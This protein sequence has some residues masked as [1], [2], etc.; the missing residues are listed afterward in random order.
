MV[1]LQTL[2]SALR[3]LHTP[4]LLVRD[5]GFLLYGGPLVAF[6]VLLSLAGKL[7]QLAPWDLVRVYRAWGPSLGLSLG[8]AV[9]GAL[10]AYGI[11]HQG[12]SWGLATP[13]ERA[14]AL[15][16]GLFGAMWVSNLFLEIWSL[17]PLRK[18]DNVATGV[19][20]AAAY[21]VALRALQRH[22]WVHSALVLG[23]VIS[24]RLG[25]L[26]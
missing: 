21:D 7:P 23:V 25:G 20:D 11:E 26:L 8:A 14:A 15:T 3:D 10:L 9:F 2:L 19:G 5:L 18:L 22:L 1:L 4:A 17:D 13:D 24:A 12:F 16:W 6:S